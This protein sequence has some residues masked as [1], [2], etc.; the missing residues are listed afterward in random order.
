MDPQA[1]TTLNHFQAT[2]KNNM[3][4]DHPLYC[5]TF[6][7]YTHS[8]EIPAQ[9]SWQYKSYLKMVLLSKVIH[10]FAATHSL[11][12]LHNLFYKTFHLPAKHG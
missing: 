5:Q 2:Q 4:L 6:L 1:V 8:L 11:T 3:P 10:F 12:C 7:H 9:S